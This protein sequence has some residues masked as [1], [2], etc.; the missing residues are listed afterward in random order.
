VYNHYDNLPNSRLLVNFGFALENNPNDEMPLKFP[1]PDGDRLRTEKLALLKS[2]GI[3]SD[4]KV[5]SQGRVSIELLE[6]VRVLLIDDPAV[7]KGLAAAGTCFV[8]SAHDV[9][10]VGMLKA[11][12]LSLLSNHLTTIEHDQ[13]LLVAD[14]AARQVDAGQK[15]LPYVMRAAVICRL[16]EKLLIE[17]AAKNLGRWEEQLSS[18]GVGR[19]DDIEEL[20]SQPDGIPQSAHHDRTDEL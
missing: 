7:L 9:R 20:R 2:L 15:P 16:G 1:V 13:R 8:S 14:T 5:T 4:H 17:Q 6:L 10:V 18:G 12:L 3:E 11:T 19:I